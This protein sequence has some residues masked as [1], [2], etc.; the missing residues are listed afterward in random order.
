MENFD[1]NDKNDNETDEDSDNYGKLEKR[2]NIRITENKKKPLN[3][4]K[5]Q[6]ESNNTR[7]FKDRDSEDDNETEEISKGNKNNGKVSDS[8][9]KEWTEIWHKRLAHLSLDSMKTMKN[10]EIVKGLEKI[11]FNGKSDVTGCDICK[12]MKGTRLKFNTRKIPRVKDK[13]ELVHTDVCGPISPAS[14]SGKRF[15]LSFIDDA[16]RKSEIL[17]LEKKSEVMEKFLEYKQRNENQTGMKIKRIRS[18]NGGEFVGKDFQKYLKD[19]GI[20]HEFTNPYSPEQNGIAERLN[21]T[22]NDKA[23]C[24]LGNAKLPKQFW[25]EAVRTANYIRNNSLCKPCGDKTPMELWN[26]YKPNVSY[27]KVFGCTAYT[28]IPKVRR[29]WKYGARAI[30]TVF[31]GYPDDHKGYRLWNPVDRQIIN[32]RDVRFNEQ[33][34][35]NDITEEIETDRSLDKKKYTTFEIEDISWLEEDLIDVLEPETTVAEVHP[36]RTDGVIQ[37]ED[38]SEHEDTNDSDDSIETEEEE[39]THQRVLRPRTPNV[40]PEKYSA[41]LKLDREKGK[42]LTS[43]DC[44]FLYGPYP[45]YRI[46]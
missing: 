40:R 34:F 38:S 35:Y 24:M 22:I 42:D 12:T 26:G 33:L 18:D 10:Q 23:R 43:E 16:T 19:Q 8:R 4:G 20:I 45:G 31:L 5:N 14:L 30:K 27:F 9:I 25:A 13:L 32:S 2:E 21:R 17:F 46:Q 1:G 7:K 36:K 29:S 6:K 44:M 3:R 15:F 11:S 37:V 28:T 39:E 41:L